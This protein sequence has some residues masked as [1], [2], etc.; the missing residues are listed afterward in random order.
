MGLQFWVGKGIK[1][2]VIYSPLIRFI[3]LNR[4][5]QTFKEEKSPID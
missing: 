2:E 4:H 1:K 3:G 5:L